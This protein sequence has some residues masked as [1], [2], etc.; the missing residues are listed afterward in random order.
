MI[1]T[2]TCGKGGKILKI[3]ITREHISFETYFSD[4]NKGTFALLFNTSLLFTSV[5]DFTVSMFYF[6][7]KMCKINFPHSTDTKSLEEF[8]DIWISEDPMRISNSI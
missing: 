5:D 7:R 6:A 8:I 3:G 2:T 1:M 4:V